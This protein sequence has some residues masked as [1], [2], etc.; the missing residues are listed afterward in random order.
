MFTPNKWIGVLVIVGGIF[1][2]KLGGGR[3]IESDST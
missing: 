3:D 2:F 1:V